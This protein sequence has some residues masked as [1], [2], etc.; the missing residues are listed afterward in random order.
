MQSSIRSQQERQSSRRSSQE[1]T[2]SSDGEQVAKLFKYYRL[3]QKTYGKKSIPLKLVSGKDL[4]AKNKK[5]LDDFASL[6]AKHSFNVEPYIKWCIAHGIDESNFDVCFSSST[7]I[8]KYK[9][10]VER[11]AKRK[12]I[13]RWFMKSAK[14]IA[15]ECV[16]SQYF[17]ARDFLKALID[18]K[19]LGAYVAS[20]KISVYYLAAMPSFSKLVSKLDYFSRL[21]LRCLEEHFDIYH[22]DVNKA[23]IMMKNKMVNPIEF[24]DLLIC[25]MR[26][27]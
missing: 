23:F 9:I 12:Q 22:S 24:T 4:Y 2:L 1:S 20:G 3:L 6:A 27:K 11:A 14:N 10:H 5:M 16:E 13:Y 25:K 17:T 8:S 18:S 21:E 15:R 26:E 19:Q 7:M